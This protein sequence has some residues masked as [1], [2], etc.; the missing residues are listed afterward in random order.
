[1]ATDSFSPDFVIVISGGGNQGE[2]GL[3]VRLGKQNNSQ[4]KLIAF[5]ENHGRKGRNHSFSYKLPYN[6]K[7]LISHILSGLGT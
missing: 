2:N 3:A 1:M 5:N 7:H 4:A 6:N